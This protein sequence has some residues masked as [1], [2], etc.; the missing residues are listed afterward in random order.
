VE[1]MKDTLI[2]E[3]SPLPHRAY[4]DR[5]DG[6]V[7]HDFRTDTFNLVSTGRIY[8]AKAYNE[9]GE[10]IDSVKI[11]SENCLCEEFIPNVFTP[12]GD[13]LNDFFGY[14]SNCIPLNYYNLK[15]FN[16]WGELFFR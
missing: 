8:W 16:R 7:W 9:C 2:C 4:A 12:N 6:I 10:A 13:G 11:T 5:N 14:Q 1:H 15:I 3:N